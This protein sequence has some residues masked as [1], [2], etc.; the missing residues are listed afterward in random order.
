MGKKR[1]AAILCA[2]SLFGYGATCS[3]ADSV[4]MSLDKA[5]DLALENNQSITQYRADRESARWGLS[6]TRRNKGP[7]LRWDFQSNYIGGKNYKYQQN[8]YANYHFYYNDPEWQ[9]VR[10]AN[11]TEYPPYHME[12]SN[13]LTLSMP[14]YTGG[15][16]ENQIE[17]A[18]YGL[19]SADMNVEYAKQYVKYQAAEA[20]LKVLQ[21]NEDIKV[22]QEAVNVLQSHLDNVQ[23]QYEVGTVARADVL[24]TQVQ[25]AGYKQQLNSAW[26]N[27]ET[28]VANLNNIIG[29]PVDTV[30]VINETLDSTPYHLNEEEC[31]AYA[32]EHRPD[33]I[34]AEYRVKQATANVNA[35][36]SGYRPQLTA[37]MQGVAVGEKPFQSNHG[38]RE[39]WQIGVN[40]QWDVFDNGI[41]AAQVN[42]AKANEVRAES[43]RIQQLDQIKL[44]VHNAYLELVTATKNIDIVAESVKQAET[45]YA[46]SQVRYI[47][48]VD[49]NLNVMEAQNKLAQARSRY[50]NVLYSYNVS[51]AKLERVIGVPVTI[52]TTRYVKAIEEGKTS[53]KALVEA[54]ISLIYSDGEKFESSMETKNSVAEKTVTEKSDTVSD[55]KSEDDS[56]ETLIGPSDQS[57]TEP[58]SPK[59]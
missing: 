23:I 47:E 24:E 25:L 52:D 37:M 7:R 59:Y 11:L 44:E 13:T 5:I 28:S 46:I 43:Q 22:Q 16:I 9:A 38:D 29:L 35:T 2:L 45:F 12:S 10:G 8:Y 26:G 32:L 57:V 18:E 1:I 3:A 54:D 51:K 20:Y 53:P 40:M 48:G 30:M 17:S 31:I 50:Y 56:N 21:C 6:A 33:G 34:A 58:F 49:T 41:T 39:Y 14:L 55:K 27:Y 19:Y 4:T 36:K 15:R 42:Q